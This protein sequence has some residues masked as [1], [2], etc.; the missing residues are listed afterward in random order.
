MIKKEWKDW[1]QVNVLFYR[2]YI[3]GFIVGFVVG[4]LI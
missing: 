1:L 2:E 3:I 4:I